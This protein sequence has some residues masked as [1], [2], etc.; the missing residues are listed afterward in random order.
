MKGKLVTELMCRKAVM[1][2]PAKVL[3]DFCHLLCH[4]SMRAGEKELKLK[5][6]MQPG[7]NHLHLRTVNVKFILPRPEAEYPRVARQPCMMSFLFGGAR[8]LGSRLSPSA[9]LGSL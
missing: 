7:K 4:K 3:F 5:F 2:D 1:A 9:I 8:I 6:K